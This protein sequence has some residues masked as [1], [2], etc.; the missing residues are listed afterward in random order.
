MPI[1][2]QEPAPAP[3]PYRPPGS[4][5]GPGLGSPDNRPP[6]SSF[7][8][9]LGSPNY[10]VP[11]QLPSADDVLAGIVTEQ[12]AD[13]MRRYRPVEQQY[14]TMLRKDAWATGQVNR[15]GAN[16]GRAFKNS[17]EIEARERG[18][19]GI[20]ARPD[21]EKTLRRM[22]EIGRTMAVTGAKNSTAVAL[23][24]L[25][26]Q[27]QANMIGYGRNLAS[28]ATNSL[29]GVAGRA[30]QRDSANDQLDAQQDA[31][32]M[33]TVGSM[34]G[35]MAM[36]ATSSRDYKEHIEAA[37]I[38]T[39]AA[40]IQAM[41]VTEYDYKPDLPVQGHYVGLIAEDTPPR[42]TSADGKQVN[43]YSLVGALIASAQTQQRRLDDLERKLNLEG[44]RHAN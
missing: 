36:F 18:R 10:R 12:H 19:M 34:I 20:T 21:Q 31:G 17:E 1:P 33:Q 24:D 37:D 14:A 11:P 32:R 16:V 44:R 2:Q 29:G 15:A 9:G 3:A 35:L 39:L 25:K 38:E 23:D 26:T 4:S 43:I 27:G 28:S 42:Y 13:Y 5:F 30:A 40:E 8:P 22:R 7:S 41:R 6:G